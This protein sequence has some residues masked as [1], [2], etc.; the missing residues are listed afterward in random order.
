[1]APSK[2][3]AK[4]KAIALRMKAVQMK[5]CSRVSKPV[6]EDTAPKHPAKSKKPIL[7]KTKVMKSPSKA[8]NPK[9]GAPKGTNI[10]DRSNSNKSVSKRSVGS[11]S[12]KAVVNLK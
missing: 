8:A 12:K 3:T 6:D 10:K 2:T 9:K 4:A 1:M 5:R 11:K 7:G